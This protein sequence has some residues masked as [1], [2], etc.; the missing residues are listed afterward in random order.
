MPETPEPPDAMFPTLDDAQI[1]RLA[2]LSTR[3]HAQAGEI[4]FDRGDDK[5]GVFIVLEGSIE[6]VGISNDGR[7]YSESSD[8]GHSPGK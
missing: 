6:I 1:E 3:R 7:A 8:R 2:S 5:H 4:L